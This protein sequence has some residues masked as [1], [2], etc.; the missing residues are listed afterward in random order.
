M[1]TFVGGW[2]LRATVINGVNG[3]E[4][5]SLWS[6]HKILPRALTSLSLLY[7]VE[8]DRKI[9]QPFW[10]LDRREP[11]VSIFRSGRVCQVTFLGLTEEVRISRG[12]MKG[13]SRPSPDPPPGSASDLFLSAIYFDRDQLLTILMEGGREYFFGGITRFKEERRRN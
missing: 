10:T 5:Y 11:R 8:N 12:L 7:E 4:Y 13:R 1:K 2:P 9:Y 3:T 6:R